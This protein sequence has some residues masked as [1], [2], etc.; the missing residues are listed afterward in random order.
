[1][2]LLNHF[3]VC[4]ACSSMN[5]YCDKFCTLLSILCHSQP[6]LTPSIQVYPG[7]SALVLVH[8]L[9]LT[10]LIATL[11]TSLPSF[12]VVLL[13]GHLMDNSEADCRS[14]LEDKLAFEARIAPC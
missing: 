2:G 9:T 13:S 4:P 3:F 11:G 7:I 1:M 12:R 6:I 8:I 14:L 10:D 5:H